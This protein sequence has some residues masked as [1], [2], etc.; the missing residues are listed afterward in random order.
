M[1]KPR[2]KQ[3]PGF[4]KFCPCGA[5]FWTYHS[6]EQ[7]YCS[8][9]CVPMASRARGGRLAAKRHSERTRAERFREHLQNLPTRCT[10]EDIY[11][12]LMDVDRRAYNRG[13]KCCEAQLMGTRLEHQKVL[14]IVKAS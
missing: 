14:K 10:R 3:T 6:R 5:R 7:T 11:A 2:R 8:V 4:W 13:W 12:I 9:A 1:T